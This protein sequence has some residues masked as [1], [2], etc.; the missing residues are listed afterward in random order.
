MLEYIGGVVWHDSDIVIAAEKAYQRCV[1]EVSAMINS[2]LNIYILTILL[3]Y[4]SDMR[5]G[6]M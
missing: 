5:W 4:D 6:G 2:Y 1:L 3:Y